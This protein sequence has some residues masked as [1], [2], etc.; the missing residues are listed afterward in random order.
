MNSRFAMATLAG[1]FV[2][3]V[4]GFVIF[5]LA[6]NDFYISNP[7]TATGVNKDAIEWPW[8]IVSNVA[9]A[10]L[11]TLVLGW[12]GSKTAVTGFKAAAI[13][14]LLMAVA[15]DFGVYS[16][17]NVQSLTIT[18][19]DPILVTIQTGIGGAVIGMTLGRGETAS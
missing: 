8:L 12:A 13:V 10:A 2:L 14:G 19:V 15:F 1:T 7:G 17:T 4:A 5:G 16:M 6:L 9:N 11:L 18:L 3:F